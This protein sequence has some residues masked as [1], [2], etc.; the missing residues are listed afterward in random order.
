MITIDDERDQMQILLD[1]QTEENSQL[2]KRIEQLEGTLRMYNKDIDKSQMTLHQLQNHASNLQ[3][4]NDILRKNLERANMELQSKEGNLMK[5][6]TNLG[7]KTGEI[8]LLVLSNKDLQREL[9]R[10]RAAYNDI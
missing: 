1:Q 8:D 3:S 10:M 4:E 5:L 2:K 6:E 7:A 9:E